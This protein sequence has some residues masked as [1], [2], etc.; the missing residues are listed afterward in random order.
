LADR[1]RVPPAASSL[2][3]IL[4]RLAYAA[5]FFFLA[6]AI[7]INQEGL[8]PN[9]AAPMVAFAWKRLRP[10]ALSM[11]AV[12]LSARDLLTMFLLPWGVLIFVA[13]VGIRRE[14]VA[15]AR[16]EPAPPPDH[17]LYRRVNTVL[18]LLA[19]LLIMPLLM[20]LVE[21]VSSPAPR[22]CRETGEHASGA[23]MW[24]NPMVGFGFIY[25]ADHGEIL[26]SDT[27][28]VP[29]DVRTLI[30]GDSVEYQI[31]LCDNNLSAGNVRRI[32]H[33]RP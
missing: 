11:I 18:W 3:S 10:I 25:S 5:A 6:F 20:L 31:F 13:A 21:F 1:Y 8:V 26:V 7:L 32:P 29:R 19:L 9:L 23:V 22:P 30:P 14:H 17:R 12:L 33:A 15:R 16:G 24:F 2:R 4:G 28:L 27:S